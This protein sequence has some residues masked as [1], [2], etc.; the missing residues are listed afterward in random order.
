MTGAGFTQVKD[1]VGNLHGNDRLY[2][3]RE[4]EKEINLY[5]YRARFYDPVNGRFISRDP[6]GMS[7]DVN[8]YG[9]VG[10]S[11][12]MGVDPS[13]MFAK[14]ALPEIADFIGVKDAGDGL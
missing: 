14:A 11:P 13:G 7:D 3:G 8:L 2:T 1:F 5:Y 10:N 9:Y 6:I 4:Y 12:M